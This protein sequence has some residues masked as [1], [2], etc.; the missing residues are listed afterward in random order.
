MLY[1]GSE[2]HTSSPISTNPF[3]RGFDGPSPTTENANL[4]NNNNRG[5]LL[6]DT[7]N[8]ITVDDDGFKLLSQNAIM[9]MLNIHAESIVRCM[10]LS[11]TQDL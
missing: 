10:E 6:N 9:R 2:Q 1:P 8:L 5:G 7:G 11:D 4:S 3:E